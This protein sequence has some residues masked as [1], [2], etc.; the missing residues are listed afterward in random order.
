MTDAEVQ[1]S[2][3]F[4]TNLAELFQDL[5]HTPKSAIAPKKDLAYLALVPSWE[6]SAEPTQNPPTDDQN[7]SKEEAPQ[8]SINV[9]MT[10][11]IEVDENSSTDSI[12]ESVDEQDT[13]DSENFAEDVL[14]SDEQSNSNKRKASESNTDL[15]AIGAAPPPLPPRYSLN[16]ETDTTDTIDSKTELKESIPQQSESKTEERSRKIDMTLF[17]RQQDVTE[18]IENVLFQIEAAFKPTG[19]D[20]DG[21]QIDIVKE[22]FYGKTKQI[23]ESEEDGSNHR[24][25]TERFSSLLVDVAE[26]PRDLYDA[27]DS[28]FGEDIMKLEDGETR[29]TVTIAQ[30]PPVLQI[31]IQ[32]VQFDR[33]MNR[34]F[35]SNALLRFDETIY[36]DRYLDSDDPELKRK[37]REVSDWRI[38]LSKLKK[39]LLDLNS[40]LVSRKTLDLYL[41]NTNG[42]LEQW[43]YH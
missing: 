16:T 24:E 43:S 8:E 1:R 10:D 41:C 30:L 15:V 6:D 12:C 31:Q 22:L 26:G 19:I 13:P 33:V 28:Y 35:K 4:V 3:E 42:I 40:R 39:R 38:E 37:R 18:C 5:I 11:A 9:S 23:L 34:P 20:D 2:Q 29:R 36:M 25:K 17:G 27:L 32:R 7:N 14:M 21:E